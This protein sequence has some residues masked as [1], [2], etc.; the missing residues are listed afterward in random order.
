MRGK[1]ISTIA[2]EAD[3]LYEHATNPNPESIN[4]IIMFISILEEL[5]PIEAMVMQAIGTTAMSSMAVPVIEFI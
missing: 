5:K 2:H 3:Q 4:S 1:E